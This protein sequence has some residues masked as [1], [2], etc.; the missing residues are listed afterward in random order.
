[1]LKS[2]DLLANSMWALSVNIMNTKCNKDYLQVVVQK[3]QLQV[4]IADGEH[5][6]DIFAG[7]HAFKV[8]LFAKI[9][10]KDVNNNSSYIT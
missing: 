2:F 7:F 4:V 8:N 10:D 6:V 1:M 5:F 3:C 9:E